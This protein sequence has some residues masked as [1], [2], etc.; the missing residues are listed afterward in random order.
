M[1]LIIKASCSTILFCREI[2][3]LL[4]FNKTWFR[5][6]VFVRIIIKAPIFLYRWTV[7]PW[8][9]WPCRHLPT[10]SEYALEAIDKNGVWKGGWLILSRLLR[11]QPW[12]TSG[13]DPVPD[14][15]LIS[16]KLQPWRYGCW[17]GKHIIY[18]WHKHDS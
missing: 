1:N 14:L 18:H 12:G 15:T 13:L 16:Y 3:N 5:L 6:C 4:H 17:N 8:L 11:C 2:Y 9:G 7:R 10:C